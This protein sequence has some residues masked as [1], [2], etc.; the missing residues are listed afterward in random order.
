MK[1]SITVAA[2]VFA[3]VLAS[4]VTSILL[5]PNPVAAESAVPSAHANPAVLVELF[6]SEGCSSCPPADALLREV[7]AQNTATG[8]HVVVLSEHVS[9]WD[10]LGWKDPYSSPFYTN[11]QD[12]YREHFGLN[13]SYTPQMVVNGRVQF[14]GSDRRALQSALAEQATQPALDLHIDHAQIAVDRLSFAYSLDHAHL[15]DGLSLN[16]VV[17]DDSDRSSVIRGENSGRQ[18]TH[19]S[20]ARAFLALGKLDRTTPNEFSIAL[21]TATLRTLSP[22]RHLII[23]AQQGE[24][25]PVAGVDAAAL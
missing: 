12:A 15:P 11:R 2:F 4:A 20:V 18:L 23:F 24:A 7:A 25:G 9:Y 17:V 8:K 14:V 19:V 13:S 10:D 22:H 1:R 5:I 6:T 3:L 16:A 21:P